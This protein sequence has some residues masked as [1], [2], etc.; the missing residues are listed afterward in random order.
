[1]HFLFFVTMIPDKYAP[2]SPHRCPGR[3]ASYPRPGNRKRFCKKVLAEQKEQFERRY[4]L[5]SQGYDMDRA[6]EKVAEVF[7][8][9]PKEI[10]K[11][12][13]STAE[14]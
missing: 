9:D 2:Q 7:E 14:S 4:W 11:H 8:L 12:E 10:C 6:V 1:M 3:I 13:Q 5:A